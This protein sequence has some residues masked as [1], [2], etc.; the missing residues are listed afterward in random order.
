MPR[1]ALQNRSWL[2]FVLAFVGAVISPHVTTQSGAAIAP[3]EGKNSDAPPAAGAHH[4]AVPA[5]ERREPAV[6]PAPPEPQEAKIESLGPLKDEATLE[7]RL[8]RLLREFYGP[9]PLD[10]PPT[11]QRG[12]A[13]G[14]VLKPL[15]V[16]L[17][18]PAQSH[19]AV[20]YD[21]ALVAVRQ[22]AAQFGY[23]QSHFDLPWQGSSAPD[24]PPPSS[25]RSNN[26]PGLMLFARGQYEPLLLVAF[27][28]ESPVLGAS[29]AQLELALTLVENFT[30]R[31]NIPLLGPYFSGSAEAWAEIL[32][33]RQYSRPR[34]WSLDAERYDVVTGTATASS[35]D[36]AFEQHGIGF[37]RAV[38]LDEDLLAELDARLRTGDDILGQRNRGIV[39]LRELGTVYGQGR[40]DADAKPIKPPYF[41]PLN[42]SEVRAQSE[43]AGAPRPNLFPSLRRT[44]GLK[45][46]PE[47]KPN[48]D[49]PA[50]LSVLTPFVDDLSLSQTLRRICD[51]RSRYVVVSATD[52]TD[53]IFLVQQ[54]RKFCRDL[55]IVTL[56]YESL[57]VHPDLAPTMAGVLNVSAFPPSADTAELLGE[58][59]PYPFPSWSSQGVF[60]AFLSLAQHWE[61][62]P[63]NAL[64][65]DPIQPSRVFISEIAGG[66]YWPLSINGVEAGSIVSSLQ[67]DDDPTTRLPRNNTARFFAWPTLVA[68]FAHVWMRVIRR[69]SF[70]KVE[71]GWSDVWVARAIIA[72]LSMAA[73]VLL[74]TAPFWWLRWLR[75]W[76]LE[77]PNAVDVIVLASAALVVALLS[78]A[79]V[80]FVQDP[81][82]FAA[83][84]N[85]FRGILYKVRRRLRGE[86]RDWREENP[87]HEAFLRACA[88]VIA[89]IGLLSLCTALLT[90]FGGMAWALLFGAHEPLAGPS[91][92]LWHW[93]FAGSQWHEAQLEM[94][95]FRSLEP[96]AMSSFM[97]FL[98]MA[99][100]MY[101]WSTFALYRLRRL[102]CFP[103]DLSENLG[104][105]ATVPARTLKKLC[106]ELGA[107]WSTTRYWIPLIML[108]IFF[109][110]RFW[111]RLNGTLEGTG[112]DVG[113]KL[114]FCTILLFIG[115]ELVRFVTLSHGLLAF[116]RDL[117]AEPMIDAY[118]RLAGKVAGSFGLQLSARAPEPG[119][120]QISV[121]TARTLSNLGE[122]AAPLKMPELEL[123][124][125][126]L[127]ANMEKL[128][129]NPLN[130][131]LQR[132]VHAD[133]FKIA[134]VLHRLLSLCWKERAGAPQ[135]D[136]TLDVTRKE[137]LP[138][139]LHARS[140]TAL[141]LMGAVPPERYLWMRTAEDFVALRTSTFIYQVL[142]ELRHTLIFALTASALL[143]ASS[144]CYPFVPARFLTMCVWSA[145]VV[146][147][148]IGLVRMLALERNEILS[149]LGGTRP[150]RIEWN[151]SFVQQLLLYVALPLLAA[152]LGL[153]PGIAEALSAYLGPLLRVMPA[154]N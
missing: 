100:A 58:S 80:T 44:L 74:S 36:R 55:V 152:V 96:F 113:F 14:R 139:G 126:A 70:R 72:D 145:V 147:V 10:E 39:E 23:V 89:L 122:R 20:Y 35:V 61:E 40:A 7:N 138:L 129:R 25:C 68:A 81:V 87:T 62:K 77:W 114:A 29:R 148:V 17:P 8:K 150:D 112:F 60:N 5:Q 120:F 93:L 79:V 59:A 16:G 56:G 1:E 140:P 101:G 33:R 9:S 99:W 118:D 124:T 115:A 31:A 106:E 15:I 2:L 136:E 6:A 64:D 121:L 24:A 11:S 107:P 4:D 54:S 128:N 63:A 154:A 26:Q 65:R 153:F 97:P 48:P 32:E 149:R 105:L 119:D 86:G 135:L 116:L 30:P 12:Q 125:R 88:S 42:I 66:R 92:K 19:M 137:L 47:R 75:P 117:A 3:D 57:F 21:Q 37:D 83:L 43:A 41:F 109:V 50:S 130:P 111:T 127:E 108:W 85:V 131:E 151:A 98:Y 78:S 13:P 103:S 45:L 53:T 143:A 132:D 28:T 84:R 142:H 144:S 38:P 73:I 133:L 49:I 104:K 52:A 51:S 34:W 27:V 90:A 67:A 76:S 22:G 102:N 82:R 134:G 46:D 18:D 110:W 95:W 146:V 123:H 94:R 71:E 69:G 91:A 141:V